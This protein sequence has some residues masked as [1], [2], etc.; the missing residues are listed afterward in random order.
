MENLKHE[1]LKHDLQVSEAQHGRW[2][3]SL[4][5]LDFGL[6]GGCASSRLDHCLEL[7]RK[8]ERLRKQPTL[9]RLAIT[10]THKK[11]ISSIPFLVHAM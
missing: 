9:P 4:A 2:A 3:G 8:P 6:P 5:P 11:N 7:L 10:G 1:L